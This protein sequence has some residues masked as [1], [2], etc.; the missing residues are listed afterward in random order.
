MNRMLD[1]FQESQK[2]MALSL[3][4]ITQR[5][6][7]HYYPTNSP[8]N[9]HTDN[10]RGPGM[11]N[12]MGHGEQQAI[13]T[14]THSQKHTQYTHRQYT[15]THTHN[16]QQAA[17]V[18]SSTESSGVLFRPVTLSRDAGAANGGVNGMRQRLKR[19]NEDARSR[20]TRLDASLNEEDLIGVCVCLF[21][22]LCVCVCV[23]ERER[24]RER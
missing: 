16:K 11:T 9:S 4:H 7:A 21:V 20:M 6:D 22:C 24:E 12:K 18:K 15:H 17:S 8:T 14:Q 3:H 5:L 13:H 2:Q 19:L 1:I 10:A 23:R